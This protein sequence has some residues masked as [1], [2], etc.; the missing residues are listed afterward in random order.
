MEVE[1]E[2][3][4]KTMKFETLLWVIKDLIDDIRYKNGY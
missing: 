4:E 1:F 2:T 3:E